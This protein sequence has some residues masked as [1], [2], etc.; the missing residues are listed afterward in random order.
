MAGASRHLRDTAI[1]IPHLSFQGSLDFG[2]IRKVFKLIL[3][4]EI[5]SLINLPRLIIR[6]TTHSH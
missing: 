3:N 2:F 4:I 6:V 1:L 5:E